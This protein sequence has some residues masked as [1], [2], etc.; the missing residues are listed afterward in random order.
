MDGLGEVEM[1]LLNWVHIQ[2]RRFQ[3]HKKRVIKQS[4]DKLY[5]YDQ[6]WWKDHTNKTRT[7]KG[8]ILYHFT[9]I[10]MKRLM[11]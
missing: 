8:L 10:N 11:K 6:E 7:E 3:D 5:L 9:I 1:K 4:G 2:I